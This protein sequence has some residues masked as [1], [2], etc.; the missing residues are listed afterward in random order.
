MSSILE[1]G[2]ATS[3][4]HPAAPSVSFDVIV[5]VVGAAPSFRVPT[6]ET[7]PD[8]PKILTVA[9]ARDHLAESHSHLLPRLQQKG[10]D[11]RVTIA[12]SAIEPIYFLQFGHWLTDPIDII[13]ACKQLYAESSE[14]PSRP[15]YGM[16]TDYVVPPHIIEDLAI[17][18]NGGS[19]DAEYLRVGGRLGSTIVEGF[20]FVCLHNVELSWAD[21]CHPDNGTEPYSAHRKKVVSAMIE[22][23]QARDAEYAFWTGFFLLFE[24]NS[25]L[26]PRTSTPSKILWGR[27]HPTSLRTCSKPIS[28]GSSRHRL[29]K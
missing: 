21:R 22:R 11:D 26:F 1:S 18:N 14:I 12:N 10:F 23:L 27:T 8:H 24:D 25:S 2:W 29:V 16:R 4:G 7:C 3:E 13:S 9:N 6:C 19:P 15:L 5:H 20:C 17:D 28:G